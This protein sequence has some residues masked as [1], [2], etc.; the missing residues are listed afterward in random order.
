MKIGFVENV[1]VPVIVAFVSLRT[2]FPPFTIEL[3]GIVLLVILAPDI[4]GAAENV[5]VPVMVC[6][7]VKFTAVP[8]IEATGIAPELKTGFCENVFVPVMVC[9]LD[10]FTA[11]PEIDATAIP[12][13]LKTG[14]V[15][16]LNTPVIVSFTLSYTTFVNPP[17]NA[18]NGIVPAVIL[19]PDIMGGL[20]NVLTPDAL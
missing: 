15:E 2:K 1:Y 4:T 5:F 8:A 7:P 19:A 13:A 14:S 3:I 17:T 10:K 9:A 11:V 16:K 20:L 6:V 12:P 18:D